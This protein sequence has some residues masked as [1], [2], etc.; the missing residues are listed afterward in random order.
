M[1]QEKSFDAYLD[2]LKTHGFTVVEGVVQSEGLARIRKATYAQIANLDP[3]PPETDDRFGVP[4]GIAWSEDVCRAVTHPMALALIRAYLGTEEIHFCHQ[5][6]MTVLRPAKALIGQYPESG[7]HSDYPYHPDVY[8]DDRWEDEAVYGV[9]FNICI[10][11]FRRDNAGTQYVPGSHANKRFP[12]R[13]LNEGGTRMGRPPHEAVQQMLA[14]AGAAL[15]YDSR[16]WHRA[17]PELNVSGQDRL[18]IL[19]AVC[20]NWVRAMVDK[21]PGT[22][23]FLSSGMSDRLPAAVCDEINRL[24]HTPNQAAPVSAPVILEKPAGPRRIAI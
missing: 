19:N 15:I 10:D 3:P 1:P 7:W 23:R 12:P 5:P 6:A 18:A 11:P 9:Q 2:E 22:E 17:S 21:K 8:P 24:C 13:A 14:P 16:M 20:P 4:D